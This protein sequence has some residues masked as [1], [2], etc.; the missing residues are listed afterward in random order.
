MTTTSI[1]DIPEPTSAVRRNQVLMDY[2]Q[3]RSDAR[4]THQDESMAVATTKE[5]LLES[6]LKG[7]MVN[8]QG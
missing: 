1:S 2:M 8:E 3:V 7:A 6:S 4:K 5:S